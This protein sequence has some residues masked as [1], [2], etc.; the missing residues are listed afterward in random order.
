MK[1]LHISTQ[2]DFSLAVTSFSPESEPKAVV[3]INSAMGVLRQ[4]YRK[5]AVYLASEGYQVYSYDYRGIGGSRPKSLK[6]F[7]ATVQDWA[8]KDME[9][10]I[11][12]TQTQ[13]SGAPFFVIGHS[14]GGQI[15]GLAPSCKQVQATMLV[16]SQVGN[17]AYWDK[18][19]ARLKLLWKYLLPN[20]A[21]LFGYFPAKRLGLFEDLPKGVALEWG[22]WGSNPDYLFAFDFEV[23]KQHPELQIPMLAWSFSDDNYAPIRAVKNLLSRYEQATIT[24]RH[25]SPQDIGVN[26]IDHFGFFREKFKESLWNDSLQWLESQLVKDENLK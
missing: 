18:G 5:F 17:W 9:A 25:I 19:Q 21:K 23:P 16:A 3:L 6:G 1:D 4:Y 24:H 8:I 15:L 2:D 13:H 12:Y 26:K 11:Q 10:M 22:K 14:V 7:K 20:F